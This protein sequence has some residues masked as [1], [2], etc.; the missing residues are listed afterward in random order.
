M[1]AQLLNVVQSVYDW[2]TLLS[3]AIVLRILFCWMLS[4]L[5]LHRG[6]KIGVS[7]WHSADLGCLANCSSFW[8]FPLLLLP[9]LKMTLFAFWTTGC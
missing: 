9:R 1:H 7:Q 5:T 4:M 2:E 6:Y 3:N 8:L